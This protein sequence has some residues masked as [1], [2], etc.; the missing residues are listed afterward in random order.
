MAR[1]LPFELAFGLRKICQPLGEFHDILGGDVGG[2]SSHL[3][4]VEGVSPEAPLSCA[5][6]CVNRGGEVGFSLYAAS[7]LR[8][9]KPRRQFLDFPLVSLALSSLR[10]AMLS[11][12]VGFRSLPSL[13]AFHFR[14]TL[15]G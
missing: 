12:S 13:P 7:R 1:L 11:R 9:L 3:R 14:S 2:C 15:L 5:S 8:F 10:L 4:V 6:Q